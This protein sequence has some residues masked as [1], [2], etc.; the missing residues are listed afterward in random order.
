MAYAGWTKGSSALLL[1]IVAFAESAGV[2]DAL[3]AEWDLSQPGV[4]TRAERSAGGTAPKAWR[5]VG[6]MHEIA[7]SLASAGLPDG[8]HGGAAEL[9][10]AMAGFK[11]A[12][13]P[14]SLDEVVAAL[15]DR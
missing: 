1:A 5:F 8:F 15:L 4:A 6:E 3:R 11:D 10:A 9:Y 7:A 14:P 12:A 2:G 13:E